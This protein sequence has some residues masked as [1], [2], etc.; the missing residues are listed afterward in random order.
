MDQIVRNTNLQLQTN[1]EI[2]K[3]I[4]G[5]DGIVCIGSTCVETLIYYLSDCTDTSACGYGAYCFLTEDTKVGCK[6]KSGLP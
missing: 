3:K 5:N 4:Q 2:Q 6:C 1:L